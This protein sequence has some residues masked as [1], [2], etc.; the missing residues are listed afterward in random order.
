MLVKY[1]CL[2]RGGFV[3]KLRAFFWGVDHYL[4]GSQTWG[5]HVGLGSFP[6]VVL[7]WARE[8]KLGIDTSPRGVPSVPTGSA[9]LSISLQRPCSTCQCCVH[10]TPG[11][12]L[13]QYSLRT[14]GRLEKY[15][16]L[17]LDSTAWGHVQTMLGPLHLDTLSC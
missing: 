7:A 6:R 10:L 17:T 9:E 2:R 16:V 14:L 1:E 12:E 4:V 3:R 15:V 11:H 5:I 8:R 13:S